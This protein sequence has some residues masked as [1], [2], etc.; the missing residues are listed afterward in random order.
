[1]KFALCSDNPAF[2]QNKLANSEWCRRFPGSGWVSCLYDAARE[3]KLEVASGDIAI[4]KIKLGKWQANEVYIVSEMVAHDAKVLIDLG[5]KPFL[6]NCFEAPL[7]A[8]LFYDMLVG[9]SSQYPHQWTFVEHQAS[10]K[11]AA[12]GSVIPLKFPSYYLS[13]LLRPHP[14]HSRKWMVLVAEN[15]YKVSNLF[16]PAVFNLKDFLRQCKYWA[17]QLTSKSYGS[18]IRKSLHTKRLEIIEYFM[19]SGRLDLYGSGWGNLGNL[20]K[21]WSLRLSAMIGSRYFGR[22][23]NKLETLSQYRFSICYENMDLAGYMTEKII[24]CFVAGVIPIYLGDPN[25]QVSIPKSAYVDP[26]EFSSLVDLDRHLQS[27][28]ENQASEMIE[29]GRTYLRSQ[30]GVLHSYEG[31]ANNIIQLALQC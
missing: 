10:M 9:I 3:N 20:P 28:D 30:H 8:P 27:I 18:A 21:R 6:M 25:I 29:S 26:R 22:C 16:F 17:L 4:D 11:Q 15:K 1:M 14:W 31:F 12:S 2:N 19:K 24:D 7:Y 5:A 23:E 13:D